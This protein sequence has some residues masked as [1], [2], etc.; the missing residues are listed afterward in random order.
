MTN[1]LE[2]RMR[3]LEDRL[4]L[5]ELPARYARAIDDRDIPGLLECFC[6]DGTFARYDGSSSVTGHEAIERFYRE[7]LGGY[8]MSV[9]IPHVQ[10]VET[11]DDDTAS[12]WVLSHAELAA[13][14]RFVVCAIRYHDDYRRDDGRWRFQRRRVAF[15]YFADWAELAEVVPSPDRQRFRTVPRAPDLPESLPSYADFVRRSRTE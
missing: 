12:G 9:H 15:W 7:I 5:Q 2:R 3:R 10:V 8:G 1:D 6:E 14:D 11:L 4:E 13:G